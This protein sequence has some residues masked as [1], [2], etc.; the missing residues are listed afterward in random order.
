M[1]NNIVR[2]DIVRFYRYGIRYESL[3]VILIEIFEIYTKKG[4]SGVMDYFNVNSSLL[5]TI[6]GVKKDKDLK[7][8]L[9]K[10]FSIEIEMP[11]DFV[12]F[13]YEDIMYCIIEYLKE[14]KKS[15]KEIDS[16]KF[17]IFMIE[18]IENEIENGENYDY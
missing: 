14:S 2:N 5:E 13:Q 6:I 4:I 10:E 16:F 8:F 11:S 17:M 18:E 7:C 1:N 9:W 3:E 12:F 15:N